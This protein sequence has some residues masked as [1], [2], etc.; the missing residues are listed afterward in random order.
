MTNETVT[1][2]QGNSIQTK[3]K[4]RKLPEEQ[5]IAYYELPI[6]FLFLFFF[7]I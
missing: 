1:K 7:L 2:R 6:F 3:S 4:V 5:E